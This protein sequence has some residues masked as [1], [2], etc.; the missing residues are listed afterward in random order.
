[1]FLR[2]SQRFKD[3]TNQVILVVF[4]LAKGG[5][6]NTDDLAS[7]Q[8]I[9]TAYDLNKDSIVFVYNEFP[10]IDDSV[11]ADNYRAETQL[12]GEKLL[13]WPNM[14]TVFV[15][16]INPREESGA[17]L[18]SYVRTNLINAILEAVPTTHTQKKPIEVDHQ[19]LERAHKTIEDLKVEFGNV[20]KSHAAEMASLRADIEQKR[21]ADQ[22][23]IRQLQGALAEVN[24]AGG[25]KKRRDLG[26]LLRTAVQITVD[27]IHMTIGGK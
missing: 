4:N 8:A 21:A 23:M 26:D 15:E 16:T 24:K 18:T 25:K 2:T 1:M 12:F 3:S 9:Y 13:N 27:P 7:F 10:R 19:K 22:E 11:E 6:I 17:A 20:V 14:R 5:R